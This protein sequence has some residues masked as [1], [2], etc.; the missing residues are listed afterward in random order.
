[1]WL[2]SPG[3]ALKKCQSGSQALKKC[4]SGLALNKCQSEPRL[5]GARLEIPEKLLTQAYYSFLHLTQRAHTP[6]T[7]TNSPSLSGL[8]HWTDI[9]VSALGSRVGCNPA[10]K[11]RTNEYIKTWVNY[12]N[13]IQ[14][15][16]NFSVGLVY[17]TTCKIQF[18]HLSYYLFCLLY[19][20]Y[21]LIYVVN[22]YHIFSQMS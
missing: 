9:K 14:A 10:H 5:Q 3:Q 19:V 6:H 22:P 7:P 15:T 1:M 18:V 8:R 11:E 16:I 20:L 4:R 13:F 21:F 17:F 2:K 12:N